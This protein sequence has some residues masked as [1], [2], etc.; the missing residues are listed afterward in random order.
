[1]AFVFS[2][3]AWAQVRGTEFVGR[4]VVSVGV[5]YGAK[6]GLKALIREERP[7]HSDDNSFSSGHAAMAFAVA[8]SIDKQ[9]RQ[10]NIWIPVAG[11]A[12]ATAIGVERIASNR[13]Y[14]YDV[15]A[16]AG[17]GLAATELTWWLSDRIF[18]KNKSIAVGTSGNTL[19]FVYL[20]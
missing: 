19:D 15:L 2:T 6:T 9:F 7:D 8:R 1:M 17:V 11:Y 5:A 16:G 20:F 3:C 4:T 10:K 12:V 18:G 14:W 13:H